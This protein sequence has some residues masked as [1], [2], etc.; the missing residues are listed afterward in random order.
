MITFKISDIPMGKSEREMN[1]SSEDIGMEEIPF[2]EGYL[3]LDFERLHDS[4]KV[5]FFVEGTAHLTCDRS[6]EVFAYPISRSYTVLFSVE[7]KEDEEDEFSAERK[8][9][10]NRNKIDLSDLVRE[11]ILLDI[12]IKK[13]HPRFLDEDGNPTKFEF[14]FGGGEQ[15]D[16]DDSRWD[17]LKNIQQPKTDS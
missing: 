8:L 17:A 14:D 10:L 16:V 6:L 5:D 1:F 2:E 7:H 11:T 12:P 15:P 13:L 4:V 9:D 3:E